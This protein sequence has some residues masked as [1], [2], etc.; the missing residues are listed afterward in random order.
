MSLSGG[1]AMNFLELENWLTVEGDK[2]VRKAAANGLNVLDARERLIYEMWLFDTE[3]RNGGVSQYFCNRGLKQWNTL[4]IIASPAL[5]SFVSF[6]TLVNQVVGRSTDPYHTI[7][8]SDA[9]LDAH[10]DKHRVRLLTELK[11][12]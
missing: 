6:A 12:R 1:C 11:V 8:N 7:I 3:Q 2:I 5:P 9:N 10:Y 4:S